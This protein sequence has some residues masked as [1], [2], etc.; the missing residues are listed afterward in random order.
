LKEDGPIV[1]GQILLLA[2]LTGFQQAVVG[3]EHTGR[4]DI[5]VLSLLTL[6]AYIIYYILPSLLINPTYGHK[7]SNLL[8]F[9]GPIATILLNLSKDGYNDTPQYGLLL[10]LN[11]DLV[12]MAQGL[13]DQIYHKEMKK[14]REELA[15]SMWTI[16]C[17]YGFF[18]IY[19]L[20]TPTNVEG[21]TYLYFYP[22]Y[23]NV[24]LRTFFIMGT[25]MW[26]YLI[27]FQ[28]AMLA[29]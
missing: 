5:M 6:L 27:N 18:F 13:L 29:N 20:S 28:M 26:I 1:V 17:I 3:N 22:V 8:K 11:F 12:F 25:W 14:S 10:Q 24:T 7:F 9:I 2:F 23:Q 19:S 16:V 21:E 15:D 4:K